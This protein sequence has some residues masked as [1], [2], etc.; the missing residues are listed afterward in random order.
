MELLLS[1]GADVNLRDGDGRTALTTAAL[2][3]N[4]KCLDLLIRSGSDVN[5]VDN[6][7]VTALMETAG[8]KVF[9]LCEVWPRDAI[10]ISKNALS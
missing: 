4:V 5:V 8:L 7:G 10:K 3:C 2:I 1:A 9:T 6:D